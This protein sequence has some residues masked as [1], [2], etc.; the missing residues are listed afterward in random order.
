MQERYL[1]DIHDFYKFNFLKFLSLR[2]NE[3]I[4]LN[5]YFVDPKKIGDTEFKKKD[6]E[7]RNYLVKSE[8]SCLDWE[9]KNE[10][11]SLKLPKNRKL[12]EFTKKTHLKKFVDFYNEELSTAN[13]K[14]WFKN[15]ISYFKDNNLVFLDPDN[16]LSKKK[17]N[18]KNSIKYVFLDEI[19]EYNQ[20]GKTII[21]TQFQS[22]NKN[23]KVFL[24]EIVKFLRSK[25]LKVNLPIIR[26]RTAPNT[27][28]LTIGNNKNLSRILR[29]TYQNYKVADCDDV[30]LVTV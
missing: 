8:Y 30:E 12:K 10:M 11:I 25:N 5:W 15:S 7:K 14:L 4:G 29:K 1:G 19:K 24:L 17:N 16:G 3:K 18:N 23:H 2:I 22:F 20:N 6:G 27:F 9:L 21:Y 26:N 13:R 28:F